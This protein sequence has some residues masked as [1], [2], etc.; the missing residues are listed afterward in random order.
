LVP[1]WCLKKKHDSNG[2]VIGYKTRMVALGNH[3][4]D[5]VHATDT[6]ASVLHATSL[7]AL[8]A[9][10]VAL[11]WHIHQ[12]DFESAYL[13]A[14]VSEGLPIYLK[15]P[16]GIQYGQSGHG[17]FKLLK[18]IYGLK[19]AGQA[20][21]KLLQNWLIEHG[22]TQSTADNCIYYKKEAANE[23][24]LGVYVDDVPIAGNNLNYI[25][26][27]KHQ[28]ANDF[29]IK[30]LGELQH[31]LGI[32]FQRNEDGSMTMHQQKYILQLL[33][34]Q[35][36]SECNPVATPADTKTL[37]AAKS[38]ANSNATDE[39]IDVQAYRN[40]VGKLMHLSLM[41]RPDISNVARWLSQYQTKP[42]QVQLIA[43]KRL[44]RYLAGTSDLGITYKASNTRATP[45]LT[46]YADADWASDVTTRRSVTG[47]VL[48]INDSPISW[49]STS[50]KSVALPTTEAEY[51]A[52]CAAVQDVIHVRHLL[53]TIRQTQMQPTVIMEDN[54]GCIGLSKNPIL[55]KKSKHIDIKYHYV[56]EKTKAKEVLLQYVS[57]K[58]QVADT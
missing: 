42:T 34:D 55:H 52:A 41:T 29:K 31:M 35:G 1:N 57:T 14:D 26:D 44:L 6:Y 10:T 9:V 49:C 56:R 39:V 45:T 30:D 33:Q 38:T 20:W 3:L 15:P 27:V 32:T 53:A 4:T 51:M 40:L 46:A 7:R 21:S 18:N 54:T 19:R 37:D 12:I 11:R 8:I 48:M 22:Y 13:N 16:T 43:C 47:Y 36:M 25:I 58:D 5:G 50:Q 2:N 24:V 23:V 17:V 28:I